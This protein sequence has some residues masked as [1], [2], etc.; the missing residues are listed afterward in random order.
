MKLSLLGPPGSGKGTYSELL[1]KEY[2]LTVVAIGRELRKMSKTP[3]GKMLKEKYWAKGRLIP[4]NYAMDILRKHISKKGYILDGFPRELK[5]AKMFD[6]M[7]RLDAVIVLNLSQNSVL[8]RLRGR[9]QCS[10]CG[11]T[12]HLSKAPPKKDMLCDKC[13]IR[14]Y[15]RIDDKEIKVIKERFKVYRNETGPV[16]KHYRRMGSVIDVDGEGSVET[17]FKRVEKVIHLILL[18]RP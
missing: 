15:E 12:Y 14:L 13:G 9:L 18:T 10:R 16:I 11:R 17:V 3:L 7:D 5:E 4:S 8:K 1:S 2:N 6:K